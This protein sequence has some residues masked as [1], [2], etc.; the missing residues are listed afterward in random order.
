M[1]EGVM[2]DPEQLAAKGFPTFGRVNG[3]A[4]V[5]DGLTDSGNFLVHY[6]GL[7]ALKYGPETFHVHKCELMD[8]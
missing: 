3:N 4:V 6:C 8:F 2:Y 1:I 7:A 5:I